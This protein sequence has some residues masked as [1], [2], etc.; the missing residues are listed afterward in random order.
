MIYVNSAPAASAEKGT[1]FHEP[2][3]DNKTTSEQYADED[4]RNLF[5]PLLDSGE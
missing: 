1:F 5:A 2:T 4:L 3:G